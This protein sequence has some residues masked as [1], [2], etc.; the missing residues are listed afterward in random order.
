MTSRV[1]RDVACSLCVCCSP[2]ACLLAGLAVFSGLRRQTSS[3]SLPLEPVALSPSQHCVNEEQIVTQ[4]HC[5]IQ[6]IAHPVKL[7]TLTVI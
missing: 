3:S 1:V 6:M 4:G 2:A 7:V 5:L